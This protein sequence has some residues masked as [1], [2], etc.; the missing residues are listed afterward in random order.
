MNPLTKD[1]LFSQDRYTWVVSRDYPG[2]VAPRIGSIQGKLQYAITHS[3]SNCPIAELFAEEIPLQR[4]HETFEK[5]QQVLATHQLPLLTRMSYVR[6]ESPFRNGVRHLL[7]WSAH[8]SNDLIYWVKTEGLSSGSSYQLIYLSSRLF[9]D[10]PLSREYFV[11]MPLTRFLE[12]L[13]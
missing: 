8:D 3:K 1:L 7:L 2:P 4:H 5:L 12:L 11:K 13:S 9:S 10:E 6:H